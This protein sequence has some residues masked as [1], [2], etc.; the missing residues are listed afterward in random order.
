[1]KTFKRFTL[2]T[3]VLLIFLPVGRADIS[4]PEIFSDNM[5]L[6]QKSDVIIWGWAKTGEKISIKAD[7]MENAITTQGSTQGTWKVTIQ[8]PAVGWP[9]YYSY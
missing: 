7:W 2:T 4:L 9:T 1:M 5:V 8:T 3:I 6:Q